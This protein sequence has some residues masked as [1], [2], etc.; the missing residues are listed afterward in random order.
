MAA[1]ECPKHGM[2]IAEPFC[3]HGAAAVDERHPIDVYLR[4]SEGWWV[5]LCEA[6]VRRLDLPETTNDLVLVC[7]ECIGEWA[8]ATGSDYL[9]RCQHPAPESPE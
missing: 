4:R 7:G 6:C 8:T 3:E 9:R 1:F 5:T 2:Q